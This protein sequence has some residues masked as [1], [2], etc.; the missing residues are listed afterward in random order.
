M[1]VNF[2]IPGSLPSL[3]EIIDAG[4][5]HWGNYSSM[6][7]EN[8][9]LIVLLT[10]KVPQI[11]KPFNIRIKWISENTRKDPD[12]VAAGVKF[13]L[14]GLYHGAVIPQD[15]HRYVKRITHEFGTDAR[16]P[17]IEV[18]IEEVEE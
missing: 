1:K 12:N 5:S 2:T 14:D 6:K 18:E 17:R 7:K 15:T 8:T 16:K 13:I 10:K 9:N 4:K 3:N 11:E